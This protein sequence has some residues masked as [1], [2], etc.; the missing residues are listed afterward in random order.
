MSDLLLWLAIIVGSLVTYGVTW[1][2]FMVMMLQRLARGD[3]G[4]PSDLNE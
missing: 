3:F 2:C 4:D 1:A